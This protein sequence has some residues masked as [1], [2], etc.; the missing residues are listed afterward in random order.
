MGLNIETIPLA[1]PNGAWR[2]VGCYKADSVLTNCPGDQC[3][4]YC[5]DATDNQFYLVN[6]KIKTRPYRVYFV[7]TQGK[8]SSA[9]AP[10]LS[11]RLRDGS[12]TQ[13]VPSQ[14]DAHSPQ[15][16][17]DLL[18]RRVENPVNGVY[19]VDGKKVVI[20]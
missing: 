4:Y 12:T 8:C 19:I 20:K 10:Q 16:I 13:L 14:L 2:S 7:D 18:G 17:Y 6:K 3:S 15:Y 9:S 11:L 1:C 5:I